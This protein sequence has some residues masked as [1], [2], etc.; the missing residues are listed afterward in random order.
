M[1]PYIYLPESDFLEYQELI[2]DAYPFQVICDF[3]HRSCYF[4]QDCESII[5]QDTPL[6]FKL[7]DEDF[8][9]KLENIFTPGSDVDSSF[10]TCYI[11]I[12]RNQQNR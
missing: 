12:F 1:V 2:K 5:L 6:S 4:K 8:N 11:P 3:E 10:N 9:L 7:G